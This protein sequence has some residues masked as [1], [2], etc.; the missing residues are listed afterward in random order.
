M[1][2][3]AWCV[4]S[5][6]LVNNI[7][8]SRPETLEILGIVRKKSICNFTKIYFH[9]HISLQLAPRPRKSILSLLFVAFEPSLMVLCAAGDLSAGAERVRSEVHCNS[10][11]CN[12]ISQR[13]LSSWTHCRRVLSKIGSTQQHNDTHATT[14]Q[15]IGFSQP[16]SDTIFWSL[17]ET[18]HFKQL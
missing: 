17:S 14:T 9:S 16:C 12:F 3:D 11:K 5:F 13:W 4:M 2:R 8:L 15:L 10:I 7:L 18:M 1:S 6:Q